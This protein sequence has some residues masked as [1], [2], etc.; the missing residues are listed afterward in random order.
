MEQN[1]VCR[2][3]DGVD[4]D[5]LHC[6]I[7]EGERVIAY[8]RAYRSDGEVKIGRVLTLS[9]GVG[10]GRLLMEKSIA[11]LLLKSLKKKIQI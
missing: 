10:H 9:H 11:V 1:I 5:S 4:Y 3:A 8:L 2:D 6:F 7:E